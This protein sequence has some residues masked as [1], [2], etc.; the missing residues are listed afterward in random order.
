MMSSDQLMMVLSCNW[1]VDGWTDR[2]LRINTLHSSSPVQDY[3]RMAKPAISTP[4]WP[5]LRTTDQNFCW[6]LT[7][8]Y[9][10]MNVHVCDSSSLHHSLQCRSIVCL[11]VILHLKVIYTSNNDIEEEEEGRRGRCS[12]NISIIYLFECSFVTCQKETAVYWPGRFS[13][14]LLLFVL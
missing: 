8:M 2:R 10:K 1:K 4:C 12:M 14:Y 6:G 7:F 11:G 5:P 3:K 13:S 9:K